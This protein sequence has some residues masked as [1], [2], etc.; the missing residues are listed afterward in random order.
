MSYIE[1]V[2]EE[3]KEEIFEGTYI[4]DGLRLTEEQQR[5]KI[6]DLMRVAGV[7]VGDESLLEIGYEGADDDYG[8][9]ETQSTKFIVTRKTTKKVPYRVTKEEVFEGTFILDGLRL[10]EEQQRD[11]I[12]NLMKT[13]GVEITKEEFDTL[14]IGYE[15]AD[16]DYGISETQT[17]KFIVFKVSKER[18]DENNTVNSKDELSDVLTEIKTLRDKL[19][20]IVSDV[21]KTDIIQELVDKTE[22]LEKMISNN[23][24]VNSNVYTEAIKEIDEQLVEIEKKLKEAI[25]LYEEIEEIKEAENASNEE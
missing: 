9:S 10:T 6:F 13:A 20:N 14:E 23:Q 22:G 24:K 5:Q 19:N 4:L 21:S 1:Y 3:V 18:I 15:G 16:D 12:F 8:I 11:K 17:T 7:E 25:K 2:N